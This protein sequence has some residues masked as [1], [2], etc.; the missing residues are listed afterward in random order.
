V[1]I[2]RD[3]VVRIAVR[4]YNPQRGGFELVLALA[5]ASLARP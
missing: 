4:R 3:G 2:I 5:A 1:C